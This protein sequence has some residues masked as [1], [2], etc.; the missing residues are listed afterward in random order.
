MGNFFREA[1]E[2]RRNELI[3]KLIEFEQCKKDGKQFFVLTLT[4]LEYEYFKVQSN[5][6]PHSGI[7]SIKWKNF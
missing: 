6:H 3:S 5:G 7:K 2:C 1:I 4:E